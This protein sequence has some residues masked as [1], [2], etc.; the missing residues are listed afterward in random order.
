MR[1]LQKGPYVQT[2]RQLD[3]NLIIC[4]LQNSVRAYQ[5][6]QEIEAVGRNLKK[7]HNFD[8]S[9][10]VQHKITIEGVYEKGLPMGQH[11]HNQLNTSLKT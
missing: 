1:S 4:R 7:T 10:P 9:R 6:R 11:Q 3:E 5:Q 8:R 2:Y